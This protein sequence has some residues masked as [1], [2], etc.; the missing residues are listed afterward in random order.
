M[1]I[2]RKLKMDKRSKM[3]VK[4]DVLATKVILHIDNLSLKLSH[5]EA[6]RVSTTLERA[7]NIQL[8]HR[9]V[10]TPSTPSFQ[11]LVEPQKKEEL[12]VFTTLERRLELARYMYQVIKQKHQDLPKYRKS[13][14]NPFRAEKTCYS[15][16]IGNAFAHCHNTGSGKYK[17]RICIKQK[18]LLDPLHRQHPKYGL[19]DTDMK[20]IYENLGD[21]MAHEMAHLKINSC[22][23]CKKWKARYDQLHNTI[24]SSIRSGEFFT[25]I[26]DNLRE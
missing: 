22:S 6:K 2:A 4:A 13:K 21:M 10:T 25:N 14:I 16:S 12:Q 7:V 3:R 20:N 24:I 15:T 5:I 17:Y 8:T 19:R 23:H 18:M 9:K 11:V 26:S 1:K